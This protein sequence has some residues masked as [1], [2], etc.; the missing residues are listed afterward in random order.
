MGASKPSV[1]WITNRSSR[2]LTYIAPNT[3][4]DHTVEPRGAIQVTDEGYFILD[5]GERLDVSTIPTTNT[6]PAFNRLR[7]YVGLGFIRH[8]QTIRV[9]DTTLL[10]VINYT[11]ASYE[12]LLTPTNITSKDTLRYAIRPRHTRRISVP[13]G[14]HCEYSNCYLL[15]PSSYINISTADSELTSF[16]S[17]ISVERRD[18]IILIQRA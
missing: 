6:W 7:G 16:R 5:T 18:N 10:Q 4:I 13:R 11:L 17:G 1:L 14:L 15:T 2:Q 12:L 9:Y 3:I 8:E